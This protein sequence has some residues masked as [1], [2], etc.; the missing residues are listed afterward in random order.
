MR[1]NGTSNG[2][3]YIR[4]QFGAKKK[5]YFFSLNYSKITSMSTFNYL[6]HS[7][8]IMELTLFVYLNELTEIISIDWFC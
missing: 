1:V 2:F 5:K 4:G 6:N 8:F 7:V 3:L